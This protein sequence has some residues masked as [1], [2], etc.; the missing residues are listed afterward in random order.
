M[1]K[2]GYKY[3]LRLKRF[4]NDTAGLSISRPMIY[5]VQIVH[6]PSKALLAKSSGDLIALYFFFYILLPPTFYLLNNICTI[7]LKLIMS[8][9]LDPK[10]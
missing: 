9:N 8:L 7:K 6:A 2:R 5:I 4:S 1:D 10:M 3:Y